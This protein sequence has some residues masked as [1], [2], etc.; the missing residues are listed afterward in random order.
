M[1]KYC[2]TRVAANLL[3]EDFKEE[4]SRGEMLK[5]MVVKWRESNWGERNGEGG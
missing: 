2:A 3:D 4:T 1:W 5:L